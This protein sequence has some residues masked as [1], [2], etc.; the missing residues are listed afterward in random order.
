MKAS[1]LTLGLLLICAAQG[2]SQLVS[3]VEVVDFSVIMETDGEKTVRFHMRNDGDEP[4]SIRNVRPTCGCTAADFDAQ[5]VAPGDSAWVD[6]TYNPYRRPGKF[7]KAVRVYTAPAGAKADESPAVVRVPITGVVFASEETI[8]NMFP[9]DAGNLH[10]SESTLMPTRALK[11]EDKTLF[12]DV[13]NSSQMPIRP[14]LVSTYEAVETQSFPEV[15]MPGE[16]G[17][18][19]VYLLPGKEER[20]GPIEYNLTLQQLVGADETAAPD[21]PAAPI[22]STPIR[23]LVTIEN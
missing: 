13:Y 22:A 21:A 6:L 7:E 19:G 3:T 4:V 5:T 18:I 8:A 20:R 17:T 2:F 23:V 16:T 1:L 15:V 10:L 11:D 12:L 9:V 14:V